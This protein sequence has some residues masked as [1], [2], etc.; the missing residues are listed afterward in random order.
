MVYWIAF[1]ADGPEFVTY[2]KL[3]NKDAVIDFLMAGMTPDNWTNLH[4]S[5]KACQ[6]EVQEILRGWDE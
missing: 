4:E 1:V 5:K 6:I 3:K 2:H